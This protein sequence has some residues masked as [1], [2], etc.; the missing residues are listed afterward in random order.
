LTRN[1]ID[2]QAFPIDSIAGEPAVSVAQLTVSALRQR[3][4]Q[5][6]VWG[7]DPLP[8]EI[9]PSA[10][11]RRAAV[12]MPIVLHKNTPTLLLTLRNAQLRQHAGQISF[13]GGGV[14]VGD[15]D[16]IDAALRETEEEIGVARSQI[17][18]LGTMP[19]YLTRTGFQIT[20]VVG[21]IQAPYMSE[22]DPTEVAEIF[23]VPLAFLMDGM[24]HQRRLMTHP[25]T[26][27]H[28]LVYTMPYQ[29]YFI[30]G[31]TAGMIRNLFHFL[32]AE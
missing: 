3:F 21:L 29:Q 28:R 17:E 26:G 13:P 10:S 25:T 2:P 4:A 31:A 7:R 30:W 8:R 5:P 16:L 22:A 19:D 9:V 20:P 12:L 18:V 6:P 24:H 32:R 14:E 15:K 1:V 27:E 11:L 23:E